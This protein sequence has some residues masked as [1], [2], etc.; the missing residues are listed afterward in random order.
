MPDDLRWVVVPFLS[1]NEVHSGL[2][3]HERVC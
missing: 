2:S 3:I 1:L